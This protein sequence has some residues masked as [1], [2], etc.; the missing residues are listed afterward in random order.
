MCRFIKA[1][2]PGEMLLAEARTSHL[3]GRL[4]FL[5]VDITNKDT[6]V[7]LAQGKHTKY[8]SVPKTQAPS[9]EGKL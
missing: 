7:L 3:G 6:G 5:T 8:M 9:E 1:A 2:F 4:A